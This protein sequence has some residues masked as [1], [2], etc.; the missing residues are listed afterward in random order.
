MSFSNEDD[1]DRLLAGAHYTEADE[2]SVQ[3]GFN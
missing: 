1:V 2:V 3:P